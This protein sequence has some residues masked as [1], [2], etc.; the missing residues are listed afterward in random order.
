[1]NKRIP[2]KSGQPAKSDKHS[3]L[4]TD[5][6]PKGT[7]HGLKFA[8]PEDA[9]SSVSKI[10]SSGRSHAHKMQAAIAMEQRA[11]VMGKAGAAAVYR[12]FINSMKDKTEE[13]REATDLKDRFKKYIKPTVKTTPKM[14]RIVNPAGRTTDHVEYKV[15]GPTGMVHRF[16]SKKEAQAHYSSFTEQEMWETWSQ[17]YKKSIDCSNPKG[18]SQRA[19]C[20]G[21]KKK[22]KEHIE[23][24]VKMTA[25][26]KF[27]K[28]AA[29]REK[30]HA[31][32]EKNRSKDGSGLT[33]A[34][35][36]LSKHVNKEEVGL[37]EVS[38]TLAANY[39]KKRTS[40]YVKT[41]KGQVQ[42]SDVYN[43]M[44]DKHKAGIGRAMNRIVKPVE[45]ETHSPEDRGGADSYYGRP[46]NNPHKVGSQEHKDYH[47]GYHGTEFGQKD[48]GSPRSRM[49]EEVKLDH[50]HLLKDTGGKVRTFMLRRSAAKEAH[51]NGGVVH[52]MGSGY[53]IKIKENENA[54]STNQLFENQTERS[55]NTSGNS[56]GG[57]ASEERNYQEGYNTG[58]ITLSQIRSK[59]EKV[60]ESIDR[61]IE[62]GLSMAQSGENFS[63]PAGEKLTKK[64]RVVTELTGD[65][66]TAS[67]GD[68]KEDELKKKG[69]DLLS[70]RKRNY[71]L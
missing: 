44:S 31:E 67:I 21:R 11:K 61:G 23:E 56:E 34:I 33:A 36:R 29:E 69:I 7:I 65:E 60:S 49:R 52:K 18:F 35:D 48:Y 15:T 1:M 55:R 58:K 19:H 40:D 14:E 71:A 47:K 24:A 27:R 64:G 46:Y 66:T 37:D 62:P 42:P 45:E 59:K 70:F 30:K 22:M 63:R 39:V 32:I 50:K 9:K 3:D 13:M 51:I 57:R 4:Y 68:Q 12:S 25:L 10:K 54:K 20:Q 53:V 2:R 8:T 6:D 17:K 41:M 26:E 28:A 38:D 16:K 43:K 5:E